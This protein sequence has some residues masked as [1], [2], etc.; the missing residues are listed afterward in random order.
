MILK[1]AVIPLH[2]KD[3]QTVEMCCNA[4]KDVIGIN[5]IFVIC[6]ENLQISNTTF[7]NEKE[8]VDIMSLEE[9]KQRYESAGSSISGRASWIYQQLLK[10]GADQIINDL[11][12]DYLI[13]DSDIIFLN[14]PY[15]EVEQG[16]FPYARCYTDYY[17]PYIA[18]YE[19]IMK[20][21]ET[22]G[23]CFINHNMIFN[24]IIVKELKKFIEEKNGCRWDHAI[25]NN[26]D[27]HTISNFAS[28]DLYGNWVFKYYH[29]KLVKVKMNIKEFVGIPNMYIEEYTNNGELTKAKKEGFDILSCQ[30]W[31]RRLY[32]C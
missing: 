12:E 28:D 24:K 3:K 21:P 1:N 25:V 14:N 17:P 30:E 13:C 4:L 18:C 29:D 32:S 5:E 10:M 8:I 22:S 2:P 23:F 15:S 11:S 16:K 31:I 26:L 27:F 20:E 6:S 19:R 7:V 9:V